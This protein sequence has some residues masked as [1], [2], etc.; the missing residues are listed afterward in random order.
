[1]AEPPRVAIVGGG[2]TGL[3]TAWFIRTRA[4]R[5]VEVTVLEGSERLG[6]K[7]RTGQFAGQPIDLGPDTFL[8]RVPWAT[9]LCR[10]V[11]LE[12]DLVAP[13]TGRAY[14]WARGRLR[15]LPEGLVLGVPVR[16]WPVA[17]SGLLTPAGLARAALDLVLP[18]RPR[19]GGQDNDASVA[20]VVG[21]R[22]GRQAL[23]VLVDPL[24]GGINAGRSD[25]LSL[26]AVAPDVAGAAKG[27]S[28][29]LGL[30]AARR[31]SPSSAEGPV[32]LSVA[33]GLERLV[34]RL[35]QMGRPEVRPRT[36][37]TGVD[38]APDGSFRL[39]LGP[40]G[41]LA[42]EA[43][44]LAVPAFAAADILRHAAPEAAS[45]LDAIRYA[46]VAIA[47]LGYRP[48]DVPRPLDG[49]GFLVPRSEQHLLTACTWST[50][51]WPGLRRSGLVVLRCSAGR[52]G[53]DRAERLDDD[54]LV[55]RLHGE[56]AAALGLR[57]PPVERLVVRWPRSFPQYD[58]GH[59]ARVDRIEAALA[60]LPG[61]VVAGAAYRGL[62]LASCVRQA[63]QAASEVLSSLAVR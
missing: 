21:A 22:L 18:A 53:D 19:A 2:I 27:R 56:L 40:G 41:S 3:A 10:E 34:E 62:G 9:E 45:E 8:A 11:G 44:V 49:S 50:S 25:R 36:H 33:G 12:E 29:I 42:A 15:P 58:V 13:A 14:V 28:L 4:G 38:T 31:R 32:F 63:E 35:E 1:V 17:A 47:T 60:D 7:V 52:D 59:L 55:E 54:A 46:S 23:E 37:V 30:R 16:F 61:V 20:E 24:I 43:V 57:A 5:Q 6:G 51:K 48:P 39:A 26:N